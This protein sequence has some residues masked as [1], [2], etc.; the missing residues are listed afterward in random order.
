MAGAI[1]LAG[2]A[3]LRSGAGLVT[4]ATADSVVDVVA[5]FH[6]SYMTIPLPEDAGGTISEAAREL[7]ADKIPKAT[8]V[9][10]GP[11]MGNT[12][13][14]QHLVAWL[15]DSAT[16]PMVVDADALNALAERPRGIRRPAG[17]RILTPHPGEFRRLMEG[18]DL[19]QAAIQTAREH[20]VVM[21]LKGHQT[22]ITDGHRT[23]RN[24]TGN[25][26][27][28]TGGTGDVLTGV[29]TALVC[30]GLEPF[31]AAQLGAHVHGLAGDL[32]A[33]ELGQVGMTSR[34]LIDY[35]PRAFRLC[36]GS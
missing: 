10:I 31:E 14:I 5:G 33:Q 17:A 27:M 1:G 30:Q 16:T 25:P 26:G 12:R 32:A 8:C 34:D 29:I 3:V 4:V 15:Y 18:T 28:A 24:L 11:G 19:E 36:A 2:M 6:P 20:Q 35:L 21:V 22:L 9:A 13:S 23:V 7:L